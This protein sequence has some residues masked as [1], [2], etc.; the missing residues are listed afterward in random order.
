MSF[1][2][3][4][5]RAS[6]RDRR[7][8]AALPSVSPII[9]QSLRSRVDRVARRMAIEMGRTIPLDEGIGGGS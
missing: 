3:E 5:R 4:T 9:I 8:Y 7:G 6:K 2:V 1:E